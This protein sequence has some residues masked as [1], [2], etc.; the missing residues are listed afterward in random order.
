MLII[1]LIIGWN[2]FI[3][4][5]IFEMLTHF[6]MICFIFYFFLDRFCFIGINS[7]KFERWPEQ[8]RAKSSNL[9]TF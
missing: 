8:L 5:F 7:V 3:I 2:C 9:I 1:E 4:K 6:E